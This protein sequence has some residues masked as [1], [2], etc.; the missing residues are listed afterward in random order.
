MEIRAP[1]RRILNSH[2]TITRLHVFI[3][4]TTKTDSSAASH[5]GNRDPSRGS[6]GRGRRHH[7]PRIS[8]PSSAMAREISMIVYQIGGSDVERIRR[9]NPVPG[10]AIQMFEKDFS[11]R[12]FAN[13][14]H[15]SF[16]MGGD[17]FGGGHPFAG[18]GGGGGRSAEPDTDSTTSWACPR[19]STR[20]LKGV[21]QARAQAPPDQGG[22][23]HVQEDVGGVTR[24]C[25]TREAR[26][27]RQVRQRALREE[28][29]AAGRD[30]LFRCF[31]WRR[32]ARRQ[33]SSGPSKGRTVQHGSQSALQTCTRA[34]S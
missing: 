20:T 27:V 6:P 16:F 11:N 34:S 9:R 1:Q 32:A 33:G 14:L 15:V 26:E 24:C 8:A 7:H 18:M 29:A 30:D 28:A 23:G 4:P 12:S 31:W 3:S 25:L 2:R 21:P 13:P 5:P 17:P 10:R 22:G 19:T